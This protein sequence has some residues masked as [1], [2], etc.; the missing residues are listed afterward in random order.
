MSDD[1]APPSPPPPPPP[2]SLRRW[3]LELAICTLVFG[4]VLMLRGW[5]LA[6]LVGGA[7]RWPAL[8]LD[9]AALAARRLGHPR[10]RARPA[11]GPVHAR[12]RHQP[13]EL[14]PAGPAGPRLGLRGVPV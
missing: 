14:P 11:D 1:A 9:V 13:A 10:R 3:L 12:R 2:F 7:Y 4:F 5:Y 8:G 6:S